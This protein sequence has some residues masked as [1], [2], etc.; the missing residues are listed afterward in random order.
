MKKLLVIVSALM[1]FAVIADVNPAD[2]APRKLDRKK[3]EENWYKR[4]GGKVAVPNSLQ[5]RIVFVDAQNKAKREWIATVAKFFAD[6]YKLDIAV[7]QGSFALPTP[8]LSGN[9]SLYVIDDPKMPAV[10]HAPENRWTM[11]NVARLQE[12]NGVKPQFFEARVKKE[13]TRGFCLLAGT[14]TSNYPESLLTSVTKPEDL[15]KFP[16]WGLPV[17]IGERFIPYLAGLGIKPCVYTT[18]KKACIEGWAPS[19]TNDIQKAILEEAK[20]PEKRWDKD[21]GKKK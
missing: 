18:Y 8:K 16:D 6:E 21:F 7:E 14:Q 4:T 17:D 2:K 3:M 11:I 10:L 9:A 12:G 13:V 15:D 19:P 5:G 1:T 20:N